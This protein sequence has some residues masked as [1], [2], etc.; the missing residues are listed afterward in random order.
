VTLFPLFKLITS[1]LEELWGLET[2][3]SPISTFAGG[4]IMHRYLPF[5]LFLLVILLAVLG[6]CGD[7]RATS[8][9][10]ITSFNA[11]PSSLPAGG[12]SVT[13]SWDV[14]NATSLSVDNGVGAVTGTSKVVTVTS[15]TTF[16]LT[17][18][19][20]AGSAIQTTSVNVE[21]GADTTP[22]TVVSI[23]PPDGATGVKDDENIIIT[24]SEKMDQQPK[25]LIN[26]QICLRPR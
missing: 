26:R 25:G 4:E 7:S 11:N 15:D 21:A 1:F 20:R 16:T 3:E 22:P 12:G 24:F 13:L 6:A 5:S 17:A 9:P 8:K 23:D 14:R 19:N 2:R 18:T 10:V